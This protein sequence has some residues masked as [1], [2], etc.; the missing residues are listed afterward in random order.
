VPKSLGEHFTHE[1]FIFHAVRAHMRSPDR[2]AALSERS[3]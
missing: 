3:Q 2:S 1:R